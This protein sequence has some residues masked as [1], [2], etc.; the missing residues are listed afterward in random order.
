MHADDI[1]FESRFWTLGSQK[2]VEPQMTKELLL[3]QKY[4]KMKEHSIIKLKF[5]VGGKIR[6]IYI[7]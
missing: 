4:I 3:H 2:E 6:V 7:W 5:Q 1:Q